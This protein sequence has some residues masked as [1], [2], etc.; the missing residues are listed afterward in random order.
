MLNKL[1]DTIVAVSTPRGC[2]GIGIVRLSGDKSFKIAS[3]ML[4]HSS[5]EKRIICNTFLGKDDVILDYGMSLFFKK[6]R[7]F[8]GEDVI[9]YHAHGND[10]I[11]DSLV[12]RSIELGARLAEPGEFS[13]RA[14][15]NGKI[16]L[17]QAESVNALILSKV[18]S[19][20]NFILR[21]LSGVFSNEINFI[22]D[23][24]LIIRSDLEAYIE[25][26]DDV[27]FC[28]DAFI[29]N[30][31]DVY[32]KFFLLFNK[33]YVNYFISDVLKIAILGDVNVGKSSFFNSLLK[34]DRSIVSNIPGTTRDFIED[35]MELNGFKFKLIDT[36][37]FN[38]KST[39]FIEKTGILK[40]F[41]QLE[42]ASIIIVMFDAS[43]NDNILESDILNTVLNSKNS[44]LKVFVLK[45]KID[46]ISV[47]EK[48]VYYD[49][50]TEIYLSVKDNRGIDIFVNELKSVLS[51][52]KKSLY[53]VNKRHFDLLLNAKNN[54]ELCVSNIKNKSNLDLCAENLSVIY[55]CLSDIVGRY[56]YNDLINKIFSSFC[57]GK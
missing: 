23:R 1:C 4:K 35:E 39:C 45:N 47:N 14:F 17:L 38:K 9:E 12:S 18:E 56:I 51:N 13:F 43:K 40:S 31:F 26:S 36:A 30:F 33:V 19:C 57:I 44:K 25:F 3:I 42:E 37:G 15:F 20:N 24:L 53:M 21:S 28:F 41:E 48:V 11:L 29:K 46:L 7:S 50:Y 54:F 55:M 27:N 52:V 8:T 10:L 5:F 2:G 16:D 22:L 49:K 34:K 32:N 6:P